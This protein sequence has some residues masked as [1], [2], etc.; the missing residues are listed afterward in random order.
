[1]GRQQGRHGDG[2]RLH[3]RVARRRG[4]PRGPARV[5]EARE[6]REVQ[7]EDPR[8]GAGRGDE[9]D[10]RARVDGRGPLYG[11][12]GAHPRHEVER[13]QGRG[14]RGAPSKTWLNS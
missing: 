3:L 7:G 14:A 10:R 12:G 1:M 5:R 11:L 13:A 2:T 6:G 9:D 4:V 8:R